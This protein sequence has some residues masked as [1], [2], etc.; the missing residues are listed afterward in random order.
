MNPPLRSLAK[1]R[2]SI[3]SVFTF[4]CAMALVLAGF[5]SVTSC[6]SDRSW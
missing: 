3:L 1:V 4:A 2:A 6:L 5:D